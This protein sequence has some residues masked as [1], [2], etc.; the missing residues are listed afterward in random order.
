M[1]ALLFEKSGIENLKITDIKEPEV[2]DHDVKIKVKMSGVNPIDYFVVSGIP[3]KPMPHIPGAEI[4]GEVVKVGSHV[5][6]VK[7]GDRVVI[8]NRIFDGTCDQCLASREM[9]CRNG[10]IISVV[11]NGGWAE[12]YVAPDRNVFKIPDE[13]NDEL[14]ASLPV[15]ALTS[16]HALK[17]AGVKATDVVTVFGASGNTGQ[18]AVQLAKKMGATV[19]AVSGK[20]WLKEFGADYVVSYDKVKDEVQRITNGKMSNVVVNSV[21]S[22]V[23]DVSLQVLG[24][25]GR[26]VFF[27]GITGQEVKLIL[28]QI[29]NLHA[30]LI[31]TTGGSR[32]DLVEL[33]ELCKTCKVKVW[34]VFSLEEGRKALNALFE[35][36]RDGRI[37]LKIN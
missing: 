4:Y 21:G 25:D 12:Y 2:G 1:K 31:G 16:Y 24:V 3:V 7:E 18:F 33:I 20:S 17:E 9:L 26:L 19:I 36:E 28:S 34:K 8:Y 10:G 22:S 32:K 5:K 30:K 11:T 29:Y 37:F 27:G 13:V 23:W 6:T 15:A 14:A 35:K